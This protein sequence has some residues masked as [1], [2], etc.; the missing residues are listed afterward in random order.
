M[1]FARNYALALML[2]QVREVNMLCR[3]GLEPFGELDDL[4]ISNK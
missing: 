3:R 1:G 4:L 2:I